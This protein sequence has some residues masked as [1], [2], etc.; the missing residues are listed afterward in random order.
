[1]SIVIRRLELEDFNRGFMSL[2]TQLTVANKDVPIDEFKKQ[3][4]SIN[5]N[6]FVIH[7]YEKDLI[8]GSGTVF[9]EKKFIR[10]FLS[11]SHIED[12][13]I[14]SN[15]RGMGYGKLLIDY[16]IEF[17]KTNNVY[18]IILDCSEANVKFYE[19]CGFIVKGTQMGLQ[20]VL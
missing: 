6:V 1:M 13:V 18:K 14:D 7:D 16:L 11:V 3:Y 2:L 20:I 17:S 19:K 10:N 8:V 9:I 12:V 4:D 5:S 15:C